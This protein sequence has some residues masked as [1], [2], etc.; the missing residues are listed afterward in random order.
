MKSFVTQ[1][2][3][4][5]KQLFPDCETYSALPLSFHLGENEFCGLPIQWNPLLHIQSIDGQRRQY[6]VEAVS[7]EGL[8]VRF[9]STQY[10][11]YP[12]VEWKACFENCGKDDTPVLSQVQIADFVLPFAQGKLVHGNGDTCQF[13][14]YEWFAETVDHP[15]T[16]TSQSGVSC[17]GAYPFMQL[18]GD[19]V[20]VNIAIGW[21][22]GWTAC[23][24]PEKAGIRMTAGQTRCHTVLHPGECFTTPRVTLLAFTGDEIRGGNMWR[25]WY[26]D[27]IVP[28]ENGQPL[29]PKYILHERECHNTPEHT[30][31]TEENQLKALDAYEAGG[32]RPDIWWIDAGWYPCNYDWN[33]NLGTWKPDAERFPNGLGPIGERCEK[34][35]IQHLLW[36]EPERVR[37]GSELEIQHPE[38]VLRAPA[39]RTEDEWFYSSTGL[40]NLG[41][42]ACCAYMVQQVEHMI[43]E[44]HVHIYRQD[45]N[46]DPL[47]FWEANETGDRIG[48][49]E[50]FHVQGYLRFWDELIRRNPGL[51]IDCCASG[52]RRNDLETL[53]RAVPLHYTDVGLGYT[54]VK[55]K[56]HRQLFQW[57]PYFRSHNMC[58]ENPETGEYDFFTRPADRFAYHT[59]MAPAMTDMLHADAS[60]EDYALARAMRKLWHKA[61]EIMLDGDYYPLTACRKSKDAYYAMQFHNPDT[62]SGFF[63]IV[64][65]PGVTDPAFF[66]QLQGI[67]KQAVYLLTNG[68]TGEER[69]FDGAV[70]CRGVPFDMEPRSGAIWFYKGSLVI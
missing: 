24:A 33:A 37:T 44:S 56:Q 45:F 23:F 1:N 59:A 19:E 68:E 39:R 42:A 57:T 5:L 8:T 10:Q 32:L 67:R 25:R 65:N 20:G 9:E 64:R 51:W 30:G 66:V 2:D 53:R 62:D 41:D 49:L 16:K 70:L 21:P 36:F 4:A 50:N 58:W 69:T 29:P 40:L 14:G 35:G 13:D 46:M 3:M 38:W 60:E 48:A 34:R 27:Y 26:F 15:V 7:P 63:Q 31:A 54:P 12:A 17:K 52:G 6:F 47:P 28:H 61:A 11:T 43:K 55:Q 18:L 22:A